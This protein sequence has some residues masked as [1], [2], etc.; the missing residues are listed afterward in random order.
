M[1]DIYQEV[2]DRIIAALAMS[3]STISLL[4]LFKM[5]PDEATARTYMESRRWPNGV[6]CPGC[7][8]A[9]KE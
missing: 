2:T 1:R 9:S 6:V 4:Q 7:T 5:Y 8:E 3:R